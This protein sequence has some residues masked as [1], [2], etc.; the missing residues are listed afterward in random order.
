MPTM[1]LTLANSNMVSSNINVLLLHMIE[2]HVSKDKKTK[3]KKSFRLRY[4][5]TNK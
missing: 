3:P 2:N 1:S 4:T 5:L